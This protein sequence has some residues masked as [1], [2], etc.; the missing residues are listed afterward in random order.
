[1]SEDPYEKADPA[2]AALTKVEA[3]RC[4]LAARDALPAAERARLSAAICVRAA[5]LPEL[6]AAKV[7]L[8]FAAFRSEID[9]GPLSEW[10][11]AE[12]KALCLPR[13]L[14]P[15]LMAAFRIAD[16]AADLTPGVWGIPEPRDGL[17]EVTPDMLD[18]V[19][20]PGSV[21]DAA[22]RRCG[23][24]GGFYDSYLPRTR[25]G[26]PRIALAFGV[27]VISRLVCEPHDLPVTAIVTEDG[28]IRPG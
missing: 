4:V 23:Y 25:A 11:L 10:V 6:C 16:L 20:V 24:G 12:G 13:V 26:I 19:I 2:A 1:M 8:S 17:V 22:G 9:T 15:R 18:A 21:F 14:A 27:Q 28:V 7:I 5:A 3:R